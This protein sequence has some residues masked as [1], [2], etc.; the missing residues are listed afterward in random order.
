MKIGYACIN[1]S[2]SCRSSR[3]FRLKSYSTAMME[4]TV[5]GNLSCLGE[6]LRYNLEH[7]ILYFRISSDLVPFASHAI[8]D[9]PWQQ[10]FKGEFKAIGAFIKEHAMRVTMHPDQFILINSLDEGIHERSVAEL[11][12][13][14]EV[15]DLMG[16][17]TTHKIQ[18]HV[19]GVYGDREASLGRFIARY[20]RLPAKVK[21]R[22]VV[23]N[24]E[25]SYGLADCLAVNAACGVPVVF[26]TLHHSTNN[27]G[28][29]TRKAVSLACATWGEKDGSPMVDYSS[30]SKGSRPGAH[31]YALDPDDFR[32]FL[33]AS[34]GLDLDI[35][36]EVKNKERST[37][38]AISIQQALGL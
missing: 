16:L 37:L 24:D 2:L 25:R 38:E 22:L 26:D 34:R 8:C 35:M 36:L 9:Y 29:K 13:H 33:A 31:A 27:R 19:G 14:A 3:T 32:S 6:Q 23:E 4:K 17:D 28:E 7:D 20:K 15:L 11:V 18:I 21:R 1:L 10:A 30:Q 12:Y 5:E